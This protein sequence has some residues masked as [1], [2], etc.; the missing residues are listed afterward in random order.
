MMRAASPADLNLTHTEALD[1]LA[2]EGGPLSGMAA[3]DAAHLRSLSPPESGAAAYFADVA[4]RF[5]RAESL[6]TD[7]AAK[8]RAHDRAAE[9]AA[10]SDKAPR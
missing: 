3:F 9:A 2:G 10:L 4:A 8:S 7:P 6:L 5:R 1:G